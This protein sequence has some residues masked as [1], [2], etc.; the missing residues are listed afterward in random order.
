M[1]TRVLYIIALW[2]L[3][4]V[5]IAQSR[6]GNI[7]GNDRRMEGSRD[8]EVSSSDTLIDPKNRMKSWRLIDNFTLVDSLAIDTLTDGV[9]NYDVIYKES[10]SN[11]HIGNVGGAYTTNLLSNKIEYNDFM[12]LNSIQK[13]FVQPEDIV[14]FNTKVPYTNLT[15]I[16][17]GP[18]RRSE[19]NLTAFFTQ[20]INKYWNFGFKYHILSSIGLYEAQKVENRNFDFFMSYEGEK[21]K[22][23]G[24]LIFNKADHLLNGGLEGDSLNYIINFSTYNEFNKAEDVFMKYTSQSSLMENRQMFITQQLGIGKINI[25]RNK[26]EQDT[27]IIADNKE[28]EEELQLPVSTV[29]HTLNIGTYKRNFNLDNLN[30][31]FDEDKKIPLYENIYADSLQTRDST[32]YTFINNS[33]QIKFNEEAN[34]LLKFGMR[35]YLNSEIKNYKTQLQ[36]QL[37][38]TEKDDLIYSS[39]DTTLVSTSIGAQ[40][41]KNIGKNF[42]WNAGGQLYFQGY[43]AGD[44]DLTGNLKTLYRVFKDTAGVYARGKIQLRSAELMQEKYYSN[45]FRWDNTFKQQKLINIE[46]GLQI[47]TRRL[48]LSWESRVYTDYFYWNTQA[49]PDQS[50]EVISA[51]Q[52]T[53]LKKFKWGP[54]HSNNSMAYQYSSKQEILP[55]PEFAGYSS[56]YFNF[57]LAKRVLQIQMGVDVRFHTAY[58]TPN[59]MPATGQFYVQNKGKVGDYPFMDG[60]VNFQLKRARVFIK[61][62]HFNQSFGNKKYFLTY[63]YPHSPMRLKWGVSWNFYD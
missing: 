12:F 41:F 20:N 55:L 56:N 49:L 15:Y 29:Y 48:K 23:H 37:G 21:Y 5:S 17:S 25:K 8:S 46:A 27:T 63:G 51:F 32:R 13:Q 24:A 38:E 9:Q 35:A 45:H 22:I 1:K 19:E 10:F 57:Y 14:F 40:I 28:V 61:M 2:L 3:S 58:Y 44:I 47:P 36:P 4:V 34:T 16:N 7:G 11:I 62:E 54:L 31:Y 52:L 26:A 50:S 60:F 18:K 53:L 33:F 30:T 42:W 43:R 59:F 6:P 39:S